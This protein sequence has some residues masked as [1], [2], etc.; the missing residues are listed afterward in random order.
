MGWLPDPW[1]VIAST[2]L[3][4]LINLTPST[5]LPLP[6]V[7]HFAHYKRDTWTRS[8]PFPHKYFLHFLAL[9]VI[10][11][12]SKSRRCGREYIEGV[13]FC[14]PLYLWGRISLIVYYHRA[15]YSRK[16]GLWSSEES[17]SDC[18]L[19]MGSLELQAHSTASQYL[20]GLQ[21]VIRLARKALYLLSHVPYPCSCSLKG[22]E[23]WHAFLWTWHLFYI[24][25]KD[26]TSYGIYS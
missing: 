16:P 15:S 25:Y 26:V 20:H 7:K 19:A 18:H 4:V 9:S 5:V 24:S 12:L 6:Q 22:L 11:L 17:I 10:F 13:I 14:L 23:D 2:T 1:P 3:C 8:V 21:W